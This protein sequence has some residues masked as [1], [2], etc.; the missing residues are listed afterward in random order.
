M[1]I[2]EYFSVKELIFFLRGR[3][4]TE[5]EAKEIREILDIGTKH[6]RISSPKAEFLSESIIGKDAFINGTIIQKHSCGENNK[7][8]LSYEEEKN[9]G[10]EMSWQVIRL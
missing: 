5:K 2:K 6:L 10:D 7:N 3:K 9:T 1:K 4:F 8:Y